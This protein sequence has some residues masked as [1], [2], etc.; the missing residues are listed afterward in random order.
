MRLVD[1]PEE[2]QRDKPQEAQE[3]SLFP[4]QPFGTDFVL[5][6]GQVYDPSH[7]VR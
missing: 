5:A 7:P 2:E 4:T 6:E 1:T 3:W